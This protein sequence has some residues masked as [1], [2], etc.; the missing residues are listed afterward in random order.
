[1][2][3]TLS[4]ATARG[5]RRFADVNMAIGLFSV[6]LLGSLWFYMA[7]KHESGYRETVGAAFRQNSNLAVASKSTSRAR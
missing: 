2:A 4:A 7:V 6:L 1:M 3:G 5:L